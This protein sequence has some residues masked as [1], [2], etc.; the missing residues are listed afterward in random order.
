MK[1]QTLM[2][3]RLKKNKIAI[4]IMIRNTIAKKNIEVI[5]KMIKIIMILMK[6]KATILLKF[7]RKNIKNIMI[8]I[9]I[10]WMKREMR[11]KMINKT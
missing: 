2:K 4:T 10:K 8:V 3:L 5:N 6:K 1:N 9:I 7:Q 11:T